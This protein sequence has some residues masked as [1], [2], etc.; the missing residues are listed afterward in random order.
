VR[1]GA[2]DLRLRRD[3]RLP[4]SELF[5]LLLH[6]RELTAHF[7]RCAALFGAKGLRAVALFDHPLLLCERFTREALVVLLQGELG[8]GAPLRGLGVQRVDLLL[9]LLFGRH[10]AHDLLPRGAELLLHFVQQEVD[11]FS[12]IIEVV[13][14][15]VE[16]ARDDTAHAIENPHVVWDLPRFRPGNQC[17]ASKAFEAPRVSARTVAM[18]LGALV[19]LLE[20]SGR[21]V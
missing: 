14:Q 9:E 13:E 10:R 20:S 17:L 5:E 2:S 15:R 3:R 19:A 12:G 18:Y 8:A 16:V 4:Q 1:A 6:A 7:Q 21:G 11:G